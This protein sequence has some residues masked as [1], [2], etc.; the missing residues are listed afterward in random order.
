VPSGHAQGGGAGFVGAIAALGLA[1]GV[2]LVAAITAAS[3]TTPEPPRSEIYAPQT[4]IQPDEP[5]G[6]VHA[7]APLPAQALRHRYGPPRSVPIIAAQQLRDKDGSGAV[8]GSSKR[9]K[10][11]GEHRKGKERSRIFRC[12]GGNPLV[13][14]ATQ[15]ITPGR[16]TL[17][18]LSD[19][20]G[21][22]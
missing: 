13:M 11:D 3:P 18:C 14:N 10:G 8:D 9:D 17:S 6:H 4:A 19:Q 16:P 12:P 15:G 2:A 20:G 5:A 22:S 1:S 7:A 21:R